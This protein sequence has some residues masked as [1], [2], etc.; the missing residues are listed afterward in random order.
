MRLAGDALGQRTQD[1]LLVDD[2][3]L[4]RAAY[5][6]DL[7]ERTRSLTELAACERG[8]AASGYRL[9][10][11][12]ARAWRGRGLLI[13]GR[14]AEGR[15]LLDEAAA[16]SASWNV[17]SVTALIARSRAWD[18]DQLL[19]GAPVPTQT[20][21]ARLRHRLLEV[22]RA[23]RRGDRAAAQALIGTIGELPEGDD[24]A[25]DRE[26]LAIALASLAENSAVVL[27]G[28]AHELRFAGGTVPLQRRPA[29]RRLLYAL[30]RGPASKTRLAERLYGRAYKPST[31]DNA[32]WMN[33]MR[34]RKLIQPAGMRIETSDGDYRLVPPGGFVFLPD[35]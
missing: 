24:Y 9:G 20:G 19:A 10:A 33:V 4:L 5:H 15:E 3:H 32:L 23:A 2:V 25:L 21:P 28:R 11:L 7:G 1:R 29:L 14:A 17:P 6:L 22:V 30:A 34:L 31:H 16:E 18:P 26:L 35:E 12:M 27:D 8:F 13:V